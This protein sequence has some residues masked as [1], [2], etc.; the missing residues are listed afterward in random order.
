M[1][2]FGFRRPKQPNPGRSLAGTVESTGEGVTGFAPGD[3]VYGN[4]VEGS[5]NAVASSSSAARRGGGGPAA[6]AARCE[7]RCC[8]RS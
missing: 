1:Q 7:L 5:R 4:F 8:H 3:E 2:G 6:S